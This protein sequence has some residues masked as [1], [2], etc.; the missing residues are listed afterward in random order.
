MHFACCRHY[1]G[2]GRAEQ[3]K[4]QSCPDS[5]PEGCGPTAKDDNPVAENLP[6]RAKGDA[7]NQVGKRLGG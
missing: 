1:R 6:E 5:Q 2:Q 3:N 4:G 7:R